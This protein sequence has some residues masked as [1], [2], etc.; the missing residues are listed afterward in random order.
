MRQAGMNV[1]YDLRRA[2]SV[3]ELRLGHSYLVTNT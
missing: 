3:K 1:D 2:T